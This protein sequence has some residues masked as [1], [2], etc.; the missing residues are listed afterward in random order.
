[1]RFR[2]RHLC[3][4]S[5]QPQVDRGEG[6]TLWELGV[7]HRALPCTPGFHSEVK[8]TLRQVRGVSTRDGVGGASGTRR[9]E[10]DSSSTPLTWGLRDF[11]RGLVHG[12]GGCGAEA[13]GAAGLTRVVSRK[14]TLPIPPA[15]SAPRSREA[16]ASARSP[17][18]RASFSRSSGSTASGSSAHLLGLAIG[19]S[20]GGSSPS[21]LRRGGR[22][23]AG[24]FG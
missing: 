13:A 21:R 4:P 24:A 11:S 18:V 1:M 12:G 23:S 6:S 15:A 5:A 20:R 14:H 19:S 10:S 9:H 7:G 16:E 22:R 8:T 3:G 17:S 2:P